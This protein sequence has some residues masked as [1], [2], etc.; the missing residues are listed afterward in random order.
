MFWALLVKWDRL[1]S[2]AGAIVGSDVGSGTAVLGSVL[3][4]HTAPGRWLGVA[5]EVLC[6][7]LHRRVD[8]G[9]ILCSIWWLAFRTTLR[10]RRSAALALHAWALDARVYQDVPRR[11]KM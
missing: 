3:G 4:G 5:D 8:L 7:R 6:H 9:A 10:Q 2:P 1:A 11:L